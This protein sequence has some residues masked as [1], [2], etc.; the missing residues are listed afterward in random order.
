MSKNSKLVIID[1]D[2]NQILIMQ[3][4]LSDIFPAKNMKTFT[5]PE[6]GAEYLNKEDADIVLLDFMMN[7]M[8]GLDLLEKVK[9][10]GDKEK[11][12]HRAYF[13]MVTTEDSKD[14]RSKA[15]QKGVVDYIL[16][17]YTA[18]ELKI[19][20][21]RILDLKAMERRIQDLEKNVLKDALTNLWNK[22]A[23][24]EEL[25]RMSQLSKRYKM[26]YSAMMIDLDQFKKYNDKYGHLE[27][28][29]VLRK[30]GEII[31]KTIRKSDFA[32][33]FGGEE[34]LIIM[35]YTEEAGAFTLG[36]R[37]LNSMMDENIRHDL[38]PPYGKVTFTVGIALKEGEEDIIDVIK[39]ADEALYFGKKYNKKVAAFSDLIKK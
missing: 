23:I 3:Q 4:L 28:D 25:D 18:E 26:E 13:L 7:E 27:G 38:N 14:T 39:K 37:I 15:F 24:E 17:P 30:L 31:L 20:I 5:N 19:R 32:G 29:K 21:K 8:N 6:E 35:P 12:S 2:P 11:N 9:N 34:F 22:K 16:K 33:R 36:W 1:D 10:L